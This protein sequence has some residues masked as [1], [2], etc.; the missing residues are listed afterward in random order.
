MIKVLLT[1]GEI[2]GL[3]LGLTLQQI[4][5]PFHIF[6]TSRETKPLGVGINLQPPAT[7]ELIDLGLHQLLMDIGVETKD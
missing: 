1:V 3:C 4:G 5:V 2:A 6:E 7:R